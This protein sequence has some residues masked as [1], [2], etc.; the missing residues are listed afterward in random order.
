M[1]LISSG[2]STLMWVVAA[3]LLG[4]APQAFRWARRLSQPEN[5]N[6]NLVVGATP[7]VAELRRELRRAHRHSTLVS[8]LIVEFPVLMDLARR[9]GLPFVEGTQRDLIN[10]MHARMR[11]EDHL[12]TLEI[13]KYLL[14]LPGTDEKGSGQVRARIS[15]SLAHYRASQRLNVISETRVGDAVQV[16]FK[17][18]TS[19]PGHYLTPEKLYREMDGAVERFERPVRNLQIDGLLNTGSGKHSA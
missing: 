1:E 14:V 13:G 18:L 10:I 15:E 12:C 3:A 17:R 6:R 7:A 16:Q 4:F 2:S 11:G 19:R 8:I 5:D 9:T